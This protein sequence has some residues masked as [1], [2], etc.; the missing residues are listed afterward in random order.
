MDGF[1]EALLNVILEPLLGLMASLA[2]VLLEMIG[3]LLWG[4]LEGLAELAIEVL[5][6]EFL[7]PF[8][9]FL[10]HGFAHVLLDGIAIPL[11]CALCTPIVLARALSGPG[12]YAEEVFFGYRAV[13]DAMAHPS[14][15][16]Q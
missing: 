4:M 1:L 6:R 7:G 15:W 5:S 10:A 16:W 2:Q 14:R 8:F 11:S 12:R 13:R 9:H 3:A